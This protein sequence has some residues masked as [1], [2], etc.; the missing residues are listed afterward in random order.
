[1]THQKSA[2]ELKEQFASVTSP[3]SITSSNGTLRDSISFNE[4]LANVRS[5]AEKQGLDGSC[6]WT[7]WGN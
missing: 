7:G 6:N 2:K 3:V 1:M 4:R 5:E